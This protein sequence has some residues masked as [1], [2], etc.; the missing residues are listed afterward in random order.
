MKI[1]DI[2]EIVVSWHRAKHP[3][4]E[5]AQIAEQRAQVCDACEHR[6]WAHVL[7]TWKCD[8]CGCPIQKKVYSP[9]PGNEACP[10]GQ[11]PI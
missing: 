4:P 10:K 9:K 6:A 2:S 1:P 8:A 5:Q 3:T 7:R 11:W